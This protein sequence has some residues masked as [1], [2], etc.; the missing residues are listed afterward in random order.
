MP[1]PIIFLSLLVILFSAGSCV[2]KKKYLEMES[3][4]LRADNRVRELTA[5]NEAKSL[6]INRMITDFEAMKAELMLS[7]SVKDHTID[8]LSARINNL[9]MDVVRRD[10]NMEEK[11]YAFEFEK[12]R[13]TEE[14]ESL[15]QQV[16][17]RDHQLTQLQG[18][19]EQL[20]QELTER[21]FDWRRE[22]ETNQQLTTRINQNQEQ[23]EALN[24]QIRRLQSEVQTL[25]NT[26]KQK[27]E[28][29]ERLTNNVKLL[30]DQLR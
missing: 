5:D 7:N 8:S 11:M 9:S 2:S 18:S 6:R 26:L 28:D 24:S 25:K 30:K 27:D 12:R 29:I 20:R 15:R 19:L 22:Q 23:T 14:L 1:K 21:T 10:E 17:T 3:M 13:I 4:K 16:R